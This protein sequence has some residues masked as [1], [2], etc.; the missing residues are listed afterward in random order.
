MQVVI[1]QQHAQL[2]LHEQPFWQ[3][4]LRSRFFIFF[5]SFLFYSWFISL[6]QSGPESQRFPQQLLHLKL[7]KLSFWQDLLIVNFHFYF[8]LIFYS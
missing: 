5:F 3:G 8:I 1:A 6:Y 2:E 4:L 7:Q